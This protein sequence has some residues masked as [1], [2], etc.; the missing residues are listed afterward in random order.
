[1]PKVSLIYK[2][3]Y[4]Y[5]LLMNLLYLGGYKNRHQIL[6]KHFHPCNSMLELCFGDTLLAK[7]C[8]K[9]NINWKGI[10]LN[11]GFTDRALRKGY[12]AMNYDIT[13]LE[14]FPKVDLCV[15]VGSLYHFAD[16]TDSIF[17]KILNA[18]DRV[19]ISEPIKNLSDKKGLIGYIAKHSASPGK[20]HEIF[21]YNEISFL[22]LIEKMK[23]EFNFKYRIIERYRKDLVI[24]ITK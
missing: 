8:K 23:N 19:I 16:F 1:M 2:N 14:V 10:D 6:F 5:R 7:F 13:E 21:R 24:E 11:K 12:D 3:I 18:S 17:K 9:N 15:M 4:L 22:E 20:K